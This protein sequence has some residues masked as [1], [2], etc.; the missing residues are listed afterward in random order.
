MPAPCK[1]CCFQ[2][3]I[4]KDPTG[5]PIGSTKEMFNFCPV[6]KFQVLRPDGTPE[7]LVSMPT[8]VAGM[9]VNIFAEG[10]CNCRVPIYV[11]PPDATSF[12]PENKIGNITKV[13]RGLGTE[14]F[15]DADS[16]EVEFPPGAGPDSKARLVGT[17]FL[18]N[19]LF[20][21]KAQ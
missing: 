16:F 20:F 6:P 8:C 12:T 15:T 3:V 13:W 7:Y 4:H 1:C 18:L 19:Q 2:E 9:C 11:Y 21:E 17:V 5:V 10:L 14:M